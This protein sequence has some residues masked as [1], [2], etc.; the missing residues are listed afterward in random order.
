MAENDPTL[1]VTTVSCLL[2][3]FLT[4]NKII[5]KIIQVSNSVLYPRRILQQCRKS[6]QQWPQNPQ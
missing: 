1:I 2:Y 4:L 6:N 5:S 3:N